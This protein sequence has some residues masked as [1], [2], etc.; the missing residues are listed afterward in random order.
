MENLGNLESFVSTAEAGSFPKPRDA[1]GFP[2][3]PS[4]K[5]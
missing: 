3:P 1:W 4:V 5:M 2:Q